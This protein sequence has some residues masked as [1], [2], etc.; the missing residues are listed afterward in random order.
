[1]LLLHKHLGTVH[2]CVWWEQDCSSTSLEMKMRSFGLMGKLEWERDGKWKDKKRWERQKRE[3]S[4][5]EEDYGIIAVGHEPVWA[6]QQRTVESK[7]KKK[8]RPTNIYNQTRRSED[9]TFQPLFSYFL[10]RMSNFSTIYP[11]SPAGQIPSVVKS[12][13]TWLEV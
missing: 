11:E 9:Y 2:V 13:T 8:G 12:N 6:C 4:E 5:E 7:K 3:S 10:L 1:M